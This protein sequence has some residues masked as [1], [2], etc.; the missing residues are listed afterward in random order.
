MKYFNNPSNIIS[1]NHTFVSMDGGSDACYSFTLKL[2]NVFIN[3]WY[4]DRK[5]LRITHNMAT[6]YPD[7]PTGYKITQIKPRGEASK[8]LFLL[9]HSI[10]N[11]K[12][13]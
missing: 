1:T 6:F 13:S 7:F 5:R 8:I 4:V 12:D 2:L 9:Q 10:T 3:T 11:F